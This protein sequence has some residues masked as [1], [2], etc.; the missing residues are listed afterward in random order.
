MAQSSPIPARTPRP[1]SACA[2]MRAISDFSVRGKQGSIYKNQV[3][4]DALV[5]HLIG[6]PGQSTMPDVLPSVTQT[7]GSSSLTDR[8]HFVTV[9][10]LFPYTFGRAKC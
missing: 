8:K 1:S 5:T 2:R 3:L 6:Y 9:Q 4:P 10:E 7:A